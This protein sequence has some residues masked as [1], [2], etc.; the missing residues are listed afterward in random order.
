MKAKLPLS[1][2]VLLAFLASSSQAERVFPIGSGISGG[3]GVFAMQEYQGKLVIGGNYTSFNGHVRNNIQG[4][5]GTQFYDMPG[6]FTGTTDKVYAMQ[7]FGGNLIAAGDDADMGNIAQW[8]GSAWIIM[9][10]GLPHLVSA[11]AVFNGQ[12]LAAE[13]GHVH[14]WNG[15]DW[16]DF[17]TSFIG[18]VKALAI[19]NGEL[20]AAGTFGALS[21][22]ATLVKRLAR[23]NGSEW[24]QVLTGLNNNVNGLA[25][26]ADGLALA[27][28]FT[29]DGGGTLELPGWTIYDGSQFEEKSSSGAY[30]Y[31][32]V[33]AYPEGGFIMSNSYVS[34]WIR[35]DVYTHISAAGVNAAIT[36]QG[37]NL[38]A[39]SSSA[40]LWGYPQVDRIGE[41]DAGRY[42][43]DLNINNLS[44]PISVTPGFFTA[45]V[46]PYFNGTSIGRFPY[47]PG[48]T[49]PRDS[50][51]R[52]IASATPWL[53][54]MADA[55]L[56]SWFPGGPYWIIDPQNQPDA[57][58]VGPIA[59][60]MDSGFYR[61][62]QQVWKLDT[63]MINY[64][65]A[66]WA[67][68]EYQMPYAIA[69][70]PGNGDVANGEP[71]VMAPFIDVNHNGYYE[72]AQGDYPLI[73]GDQAIYTVMHTYQDA[74]SLHP[75]L[76][77]DLHIMAYAY[78]NANDSDLWNTVFMNV[79]VIN[80]GDAT[81]TGVR[82]GMNMG[83]VIGNPDNDLA[84]CDTTLNLFYAYNGDD[85]D[86]GIDYGYGDQPPAQGA[87]FLNQ[88]MT[89]H[90]AFPF[91]ESPSDED[92]INGTLNGQPFTQTGY[93][94]HCQYPGGAF[95]DDAA[96][97]APGDRRSVGSIGPFT[98][99]PGDTL[100]IDLA[101]PFANA[102]SGGALAS[103]AALKTRAHNLNGWYGA[104]HFACLSQQ[105]PNGITE[106][107]AGHFAL[108][109][110]PTN[111]SITMERAEHGEQAQIEVH[112]MSGR[113]VMQA[114]WRASSTRIG[115][116]VSSLPSGIYAVEVRTQ[117]GVQ[118][119]RL[120]KQ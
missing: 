117:E 71:A 93:P 100:C 15:T 35:S 89:A 73:R 113:L 56:H 44:A 74:D 41:V 88:K 66:H 51:T 6:A 75:P 32:S 19:Y 80:R 91:D 38:V 7:L 106:L 110:N 10:S 94:S 76:P 8:D 61:R 58:Y 109:P 83:F 86:E 55:T 72:P 25:A 11:M 78:G 92:Q 119:Q 57:S 64:H 24:E 9:G 95:T 18:Q 101:F 68:A 116:D 47:D 59:N 54:G 16:E 26:T 20:Y 65:I 67:D 62:Y 46:G 49:V 52:S 103:V 27:G 3:D 111:G 77:M 48:F 14:R 28:N 39:G 1:F 114:D 31:S 104:Q 34:F 115:L 43:Q 98:L 13:T 97:N 23:W 2:T 22:G 17:G 50:A 105:L 30:N 90:S 12:L 107:D 79:E 81:Y 42:Q 40:T 60:V 63:A 108:Y 118:V 120:V 21:G 36:Y 87:L 53:T 112:A 102:A 82:F 5:D 45:D 96:G 85:M 33:C 4:W 69:S 29:T 99:G 37:R 84:G 70:W